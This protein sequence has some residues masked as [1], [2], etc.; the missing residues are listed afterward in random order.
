MNQK[1]LPEQTAH[2]IETLVHR[3]RGC[4]VMIDAD[5]AALYGVENRAL[6]QAVRRHPERFPDDFM[7]RL[8]E[9]EFAGL[10]SQIVIS[11]GRGGRRHLPIAFTEQGVAMLSSVLNS[12][13][14]IR[15]NIHI[16]RAFTRLRELALTH[17]RLAEELARLKN[18]LGLHD[19]SI[20]AILQILDNL[21]REP[22]RPGRKI[23]FKVKP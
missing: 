19:A 8:T 6:L 21:L 7:F 10:R 9:E 18:Q 4:R 14:A 1:N 17:E 5:L 12:D 22:P 11:N 20:N 16:M 15:V 3:I 13:R 2:P 23:G